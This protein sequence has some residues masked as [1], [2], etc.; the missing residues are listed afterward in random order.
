M[1]AR[2]GKVA[3]RRWADWLIFSLTRRPITD[4]KTRRLF[5]STDRSGAGEVIVNIVGAQITKGFV[6]EY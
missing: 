3:K 6:D 2:C 1:H 5:V 4:A